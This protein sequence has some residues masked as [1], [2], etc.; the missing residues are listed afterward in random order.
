MLCKQLIGWRR[1]LGTHN[2]YYKTLT[3]KSNLK[4]INENQFLLIPNILHRPWH[5]LGGANGVHISIYNSKLYLQSTNLSTTMFPPIV[6]MFTLQFPKFPYSH[7]VTYPEDGSG[8]AMLT[9][10]RWHHSF[11][12]VITECWAI[13]WLCYV[14]VIHMKCWAIHWL[15]YVNVIH[16]KCWVIHWLCYVNVIHMN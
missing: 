1:K 7:Q 14:N 10:H 12:T 4:N 15:C 9:D 16:M 11:G 8:P 13:H 6:P 2:S 5:R 3:S